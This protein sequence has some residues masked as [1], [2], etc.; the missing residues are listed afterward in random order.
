MITRPSCHPRS[1]T[2]SS[3]L[4][5]GCATGRVHVSALDSDWLAGCRPRVRAVV[6]AQKAVHA[7]CKLVANRRQ[8]FFLR[9]FVVVSLKC[10]VT[11]SDL[12]S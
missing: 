9:S 5:G 1:H 8:I 6:D 11:N 3:A 4:P 7:I 10:I 12:P 2:C